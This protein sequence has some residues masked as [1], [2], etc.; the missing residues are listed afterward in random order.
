MY[1]NLSPR[2]IEILAPTT[3]VTV[4]ELVNAIRA[5]EDSELGQYY[6][7]LL[8]AD[9][10][11]PLTGDVEVG[12]TATLQNAK[13]MFSGRTTSYVHDDTVTSDNTLGTHLHATGGNFETNGVIPG[14]TLINETTHGI[15]SVVEVISEEEL[16]CLPSTGGT[17]VSW[18]SGDIY[19]I[20]PNI[21]CSI[22]GGNLVALDILGAEITPIFPSFKYRRRILLRWL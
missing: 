4:Q 1:P 10:K 18:I 22:T 5:W 19:S 16:I 17:R 20:Y 13:V 15:T 3:D 9:G 11:Q 2:I 7:F 12:I 8:E 14:A 6:P 21:E